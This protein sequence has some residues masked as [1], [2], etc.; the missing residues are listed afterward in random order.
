MYDKGG[1]TDPLALNSALRRLPEAL[2]KNFPNVKTWTDTAI[3]H[4]EKFKMAEPWPIRRNLGWES[5]HRV[6]STL[7]GLQEIL[8]FR[9]FA[10]VGD[11][12]ALKRKLE[13]FCV[14]V[15]A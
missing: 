4:P 14:Q 5:L 3:D 10:D 9:V 6:S 15:V 12:E 7:A 2:S 13:S 1:Y 11:D 8:W